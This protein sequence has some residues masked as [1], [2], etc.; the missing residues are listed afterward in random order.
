MSWCGVLLFMDATILSWDIFTLVLIIVMFL[1]N[2]GGGLSRSPNSHQNLKYWYG[3][4]WWGKFLLRTLCSIDFKLGL[5]G[6]L[7]V[8]TIWNLY[9]ILLYSL[10]SLRGCGTLASHGWGQDTIGL[11]PLSRILGKAGMRVGLLRC[12]SIYS[13]YSFLGYLGFP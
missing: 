4:S 5:I 6:V 1:W 10:L 8:R 9:I 11:V 12:I 2:S 3:V 13:D 7:C